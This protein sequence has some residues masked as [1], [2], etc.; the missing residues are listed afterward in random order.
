MLTHLNSLPS[1]STAR[2]RLIQYVQDSV[3]SAILD[4]L[5]QHIPL[6]KGTVNAKKKKDAELVPEASSASSASVNAISKCYIYY[7]VESLWPTGAE[8]MASLAGA[9]YGMMIRLLPSYVRNWF[10]GLRDRSLSS[11]VEAF[12]KEWCSPPLLM[13]ELSKVSSLYQL[14]FY[15]IFFSRKI[16]RLAS[17]FG[18][19]GGGEDFPSISYY[20]HGNTN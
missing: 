9:L 3:S 12:T 17:F 20:S 10:S 2:E 7:Y 8:Q 18:G 15:F 6:K 1:S 19:G 11:A 14:I 5:F 4:C 13:D 16:D